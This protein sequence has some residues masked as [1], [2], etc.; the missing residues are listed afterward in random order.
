MSA[1][2]QLQDFRIGVTNFQ[3][4]VTSFVAPRVSPVPTGRL[5]LAPSNLSFPPGVTNAESGELCLNGQ[6]SGFAD[7][8][9]LR[10]EELAYPSST[11]MPRY[12]VMENDGYPGFSGLT[13][14]QMPG[15]RVRPGAISGSDTTLPVTDFAEQAFAIAAGSVAGQ[16]CAT[17]PG[18][19]IP[20]AAATDGVL[21]VKPPSVVG[22]LQLSGSITAANTMS[23][24]A[25]NPSTTAQSYPAGKY[26]AFLLG[27]AASSTT[28]ATSGGT[29]VN[30]SPL[31][32]S[33]GDLVVGDVN[34]NPSRLPGN[35]TTTAAVLME[36]GTGTGA[37]VPA[38]QTAP[39]FFGGNLT[40]LNAANIT[41]GAVG[42]ANGGTSANT[43]LQ[44]LANLG[45]ASLNASVSAF[46]GSLT[47]KQVGGLYQVDQFAGSDI[48]A[49]LT[50]C[51]AGLNAAYGGVCDARNFSGTVTMASSVT[52]GTANTT[53]LLP[54]ATISGAGQIV[55]QAGIRN[56]TLKGCGLRG[57]STASGSQGGTVLLYSGTGAAVQVGDA[58]Y[59]ADTMGFHM[60][61]LVINTTGSLSGLTEGFAAYRVQ[62]LDL[63]SVYFLGNGNQTA[64]LVDGT[65]NYAGGTFVD[66]AFNGFQTAVSGIGHQVTNPATTDW[67]NAST[68][69][70]LHIDCPT[71]SG[72]PVAGTVGIDLAQGDGNT[73][74]G[75]DV[76]GCSTALHLGAN[77]QNNTIVGLR[78]ENSSSQVVADTGSA[79]N[80]WVTGG[81]M[82]TGALTDNGTRNSFLD[83]FHRAF[84][85]MNGD[86]YGSQKDATVTNHLTGRAREMSG[87]SAKT[88]PDRLWVSVDDGT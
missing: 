1:A 59:A 9:C 83:S 6:N 12:M 50:A 3:S 42:I 27:G 80:S 20:N 75:G 54:C 5:V 57:A 61:N 55:V 72:S 52:V 13:A 25:C 71:S 58:T 76:E 34:G 18:I 33:T 78:N 37:N 26:Y 2:Q 22:Q 86:W 29:P 84:N 62:E 44:A 16:T 17:V 31:T 74:T 23:L 56:V 65:G 43:A 67:M 73:F 63:N 36:S 49:K 85:G 68:F 7:L 70:R 53:V 51:I 39:S 19:S 66:L 4:K 8:W 47:G 46:A 81:T 88:I 64:M 87:A 77:A 30:T 14:V 38:W 40:G 60:D 21:F 28:P 45:G 69:L 82:F 15:L 24:T 35:T 79:Y 32:T 48:G 41:T 11:A 10:A